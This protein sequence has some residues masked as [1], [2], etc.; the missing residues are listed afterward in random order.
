MECPKCHAPMRTYERNGIHI[1]QCTE[2]RGVF[3]DRGELDH[4]ISLEAAQAEPAPAPAPAAA[5]PA[6]APQQQQ[7][8]QP[9]AYPQ[10]GYQQPGYQ[11]QGYQQGYG[12]KPYKKRKNFLEEL[13]D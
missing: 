9:Q 8:P 13:F 1:D 2:C 5:A 11:Q 12:G 7:Q 10:Q 6:Y 3:L 4:L